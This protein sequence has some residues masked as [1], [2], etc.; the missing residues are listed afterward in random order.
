[1]NTHLSDLEFDVL[2]RLNY[3]FVVK[4]T[5]RV[6]RLELPVISCLEGRRRRRW[7][8]HAIEIYNKRI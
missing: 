4:K 8:I 2:I 3:T 1:M 7:A 6:G 5:V